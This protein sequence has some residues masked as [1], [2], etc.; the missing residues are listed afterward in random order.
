M[1]KQFITKTDLISIRKW[2]D[3]LIKKYMPVPD[4]IKNNPHFKLSLEVFF[5]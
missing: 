3:R 2:T 1:T 5:T 4:T